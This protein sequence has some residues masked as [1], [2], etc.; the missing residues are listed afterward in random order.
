MVSIGE[1]ELLRLQLYESTTQQQAP[2]E[3]MIL[4]S[5]VKAAAFDPQVSVTST[6]SAARVLFNVERHRWVDQHGCPHEWQAISHTGDHVERLHQ[7][8][9]GVTE[10]RE[11]MTAVTEAL[12]SGLNGDQQ[13]FDLLK[14]HDHH[15]AGIAVDLETTR[16]DTAALG[17]AVTAAQRNIG[18]LWRDHRG[19]QEAHNTALSTVERSV[20]ELL[21]VAA[22]ARLRRLEESSTRA[23]AG[24]K[25]CHAATEGVRASVDAAG[26]QLSSHIHDVSSSLNDMGQRVGALARQEATI[27]KAYERIAQE[28]AEIRRV[29]APLEQVTTLQRVVNGLK[30]KVGTLEGHYQTLKI[31]QTTVIEQLDRTASLLDERTITIKA[32]TSRLNYCEQTLQRAL[33]RITIMEKGT[34][35]STESPP[36]EPPNDPPP[37]NSCSGSDGCCRWCASK[38]SSLEDANQALEHEVARLNTQVVDLRDRVLHQSEDKA[39]WKAE[40]LSEMRE[41]LEAIRRQHLEEIR[42]CHR[43]LILAESGSD[44][45]QTEVMNPLARRVHEVDRQYAS[46]KRQVQHNAQELA[47]VKGR[48]QVPGP[49]AQLPDVSTSLNFDVAAVEARVAEH[50]TSLRALETQLPEVVNGMET[51]AH[52]MEVLEGK[53]QEWEDEC[54][55]DG[56]DGRDTTTPCQSVNPDPSLSHPTYPVKAEPGAPPHVSTGEGTRFSHCP[57]GETTPAPGVG[58]FSGLG[59]ILRPHTNPST[60]KPPANAPTLL[61]EAGGATFDLPGLVMKGTT[62]DGEKHVSFSN[63]QEFSRVTPSQLWVTCLRLGGRVRPQSWAHPT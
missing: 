39:S 32:T 19:L 13:V 30:P 10:L 25:S 24:I 15:F 12:R 59:D 38:V 50:D 18:D 23:E 6:L 37:S 44:R 49:P 51:L 56:E 27:A 1:P 29:T 62:H 42:D 22:A 34:G 47:L 21:Q 31:R 58:Q 33:N 61:H 60:P 55:D 57:Y 35:A 48:Q 20:N 43:R 2:A 8:E 11:A 9:D 63:V 7:V 41:S 40:V 3:P 28:T 16:G 14:T 46:L 36:P 26:L 5:P 53:L 54:A 17:N 4:S 45:L 52:A